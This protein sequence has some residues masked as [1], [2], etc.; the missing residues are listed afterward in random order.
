MKYIA[1]LDSEI[2]DLTAFTMMEAN[3]KETRIAV[4][5]LTALFIDEI[6]Q[7]LEKQHKEE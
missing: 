5:P 4:Y 2:L 6:K 3:G 7:E 1:I